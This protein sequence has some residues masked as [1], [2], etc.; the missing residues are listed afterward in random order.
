MKRWIQVADAA[1]LPPGAGRTVAAGTARVALFN[2]AGEFL[3]LDDACP[4]QGGSLGGGTV[5][6]GRVICPLHSWVFELRSGRCPRDTHA[7]V[8]T[9]PARCRDGVVEVEIAGEA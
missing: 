1:S 5:H 9:H 6:Q 4:H 3:A 8:A 7:P 2:D